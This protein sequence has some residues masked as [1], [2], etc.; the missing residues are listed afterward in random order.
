MLRTSTKKTLLIKTYH[1]DT[2]K[3]G[4]FSELRKH[5]YIFLYMWLN[6]MNDEILAICQ[7]TALVVLPN[8]FAIFDIDNPKSR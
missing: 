2:T 4:I 7:K 1:Y 5:P 6:S 8:S 3:V